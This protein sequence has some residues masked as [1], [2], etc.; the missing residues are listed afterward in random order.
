LI[1]VYYIKKEVCYCIPPP[2]GFSPFLIF[3][4][5]GF[6]G[7]NGGGNDGCRHE[8]DDETGARISLSYTRTRL[9]SHL[10]PIT[11]EKVL[12]IFHLSVFNFFL[13]LTI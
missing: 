6:L 13:F 5:K 10:S 1:N 4:K 2:D 12:A 11:D 8:L 3:L 9:T 7:E